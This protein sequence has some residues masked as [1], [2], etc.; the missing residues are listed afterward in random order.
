MAQRLGSKGLCVESM[1]VERLG[2]SRFIIVADDRPIGRRNFHY[3][4]LSASVLY[5]V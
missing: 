1:V 2:I 5:C 3:V 4:S